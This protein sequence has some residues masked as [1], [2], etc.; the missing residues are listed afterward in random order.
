MLI[1]KLKNCTTNIWLFSFFINCLQIFRLHG[2]E[3]N[4]V[5]FLKFHFLTFSLQSNHV[6]VCMDAEQNH[7]LVDFGLHLI[8]PAVISHAQMNHTTQSL[9]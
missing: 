1:V 5:H 7:F 9:I 3:L 4:L 6:K 2:L 8:A